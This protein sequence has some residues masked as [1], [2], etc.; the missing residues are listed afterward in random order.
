MWV[1]CFFFLHMKLNTRVQSLQATVTMGCQMLRVSTQCFLKHY[2]VWFSKFGKKWLRTGLAICEGL[3]KTIGISALCSWWHHLYSV[4]C[5]HHR[6]FLFSFPSLD[7]CAFPACVKKKKKKCKKLVPRLG[8]GF[9]VSNATL[10][11]RWNLKLWRAW[12]TI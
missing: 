2:G 3:H 6:R 4:E 1:E 9:S 12:V 11:P 10:K 8:V 7:R 5:A